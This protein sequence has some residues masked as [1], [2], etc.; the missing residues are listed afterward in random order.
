MANL[1]P[2]LKHLLFDLD[3]TLY[4]TSNG[5]MQEISVRMSEF[6]RARVGIPADQVEFI[7]RDYWTRYGT[8]LRGLYI[9][10]QIDAQA[11]LDFVHDVPIEKYLE[12]DARLAEMLAGL[13]YQK[14][15]F[16]NAPANYARRVL[17]IL[18]VNNQFAEIFDIN[19]ISYE[20]KPAPS[21]YEKV[22]AALQARA[23]E[24]CL[25][26][27]SARNL[28]PAKALGMRT[29]LLDGNPKS[30]GGERASADFIIR[31]VYDVTKIVF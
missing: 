14:H 11:F 5:L 9:E 12:A 19:F 20:S 25:I 29:V 17:T 22:L 26:D 4:P 28:A 15:I 18:G 23:D 10:R 13:T 7:R 6:M 2:M 21:G 27:D 1:V 31:S 30:H 8:T 3:E 24:C 16:T